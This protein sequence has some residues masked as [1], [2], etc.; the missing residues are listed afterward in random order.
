MRVI[1]VCKSWAMAAR[2]LNG[3]LARVASVASRFCLTTPLAGTV[4]AGPAME[5][6]AGVGS[7]FSTWVPFASCADTRMRSVPE[8]AA[9]VQ[10]QSIR[11]ALMAVPAD[12][13][14]LAHAL[15]DVLHVPY[16]RA[17][18]RGYDDVVREGFFGGVAEL[19]GV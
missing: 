12:G 7:S 19:L 14:L 17:F 10:K 6:S 3:P 2:M 11:L 15:D 13:A 5:Y 16:R 4:N 9:T 1:G 18:M 8:L